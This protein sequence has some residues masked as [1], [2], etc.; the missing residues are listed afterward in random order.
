MSQFP[1]PVSSK[2][3]LKLGY[4]E[5]LPATQ[6]QEINMREASKSMKKGWSRIKEVSREKKADMEDEMNA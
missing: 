3:R 1:P 5:H 6:L 2:K 4:Q